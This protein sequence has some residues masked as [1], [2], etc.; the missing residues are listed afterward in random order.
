MQA[1]VR[2]FRTYSNLDAEREKKWLLLIS[3]ST[4]ICYKKSE[5]RNCKILTKRPYIRLVAIRYVSKKLGTHV[6]RSSNDLR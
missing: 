5:Q 2:Q 6:V 3:I 4:L 1:D